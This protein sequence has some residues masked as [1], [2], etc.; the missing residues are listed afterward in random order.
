MKKIKLCCFTV[1]TTHAYIIANNFIERNL[2]NVKVIYINEKD[3]KKK[4]KSI[5]ARFYKRMNDDMYYTEWLNEKIVNE[6]EFENF[7][8]VVHGKEEFVTKVNKFLDMNESNGYIINCF[9]IFN[10]SENISK[11]IEEHDYYIN[12]SGMLKKEGFIN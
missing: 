10:M 1:N 2:Q 3:E 9:D 11:I 8:F 5:I 12:T 7:V 6:Y 4:T